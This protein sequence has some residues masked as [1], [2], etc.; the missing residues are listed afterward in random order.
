VITERTPS[1]SISDIT[2]AR[3]GLLTSFKTPG[4]AELSLY[5]PK[6]PTAIQAHG[7]AGTVTALVGHSTPAAQASLLATLRVSLEPIL[8]AERVPLEFTLKPGVR[9]RKTYGRCTWHASGAPP[10][11]LVRCTADAD[12]SRWRGVGAI[13]GTLLHE[14]AHLRYRSHGPRFWALHRRLVDR[15]AAAGV[16]DPSDRDPAE[17]ARG[18]EKLAGSAAWMIALAARR[19]RRERVGVNRAR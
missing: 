11:V 17:R 3:F 6:H 13:V 15:A 9:L 16:Y 4:G 18:D 8:L 10:T 19:R 7:R 12:R 1:F 14:L 2:D 5:E